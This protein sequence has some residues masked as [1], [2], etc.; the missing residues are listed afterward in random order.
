MSIGVRHLLH[1]AEGLSGADLPVG[2]RDAE[3][4]DCLARGDVLELRVPDGLPG[5]QF[6]GGPAGPRLLLAALR[7]SLLMASSAR[8]CQTA[9]PLSLNT[10]DAE[11]SS[12]SAVA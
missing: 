9:S 12:V 6:C 10:A 4:V 1:Q 3:D 8:S 5:D 2:N 7:R 11:S